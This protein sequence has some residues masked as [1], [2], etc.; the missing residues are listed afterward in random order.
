MNNSE[1]V[2]YMTQTTYYQYQ[3]NGRYPVYLRFENNEVEE[4]LQDILSEM[5]FIKL[6]AISLKKIQLNKHGTRVLKISKASA[7]VAKEIKAYSGMD[8][9]GNES[10]TPMSQYSVYRYRNAGMMMI[11]TQ[12]ITW[13]LGLLLEASVEKTP[14][15]IILTRFL[16][17]ALS[18]LGVVGFWGTI[19]ENSFFI[20]K[21]NQSAG[22]SFFVD[23]KN[24][25]VLTSSEQ[26]L[27]HFDQVVR[28]DEG[29]RGKNK[30]LSK[31]E[32]IGFLSANT[33]YMSTS[34][35]TQQIRQACF[36]LGSSL[37]GILVPKDDE[38]SITN[39]AA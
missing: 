39:M 21:A 37:E 11:N 2:G 22:K 35:I 27:F 26:D 34:G 18:P 29:V 14:Y 32:L 19:E 33:A 25:K 15:R 17:H 7:K 8:Q 9:Y 28:M 3:Q 10:M 6:D 16:S 38:L 36:D 30:I 24:Q 31:E 13:E 1:K 23:Y 20:T 12:N 5:G 4:A